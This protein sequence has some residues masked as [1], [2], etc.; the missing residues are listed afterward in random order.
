MLLSYTDLLA[1]KSKGVATRV[2]RGEMRCSVA[3]GVT[4]EINSESMTYCSMHWLP[5][6]L[7]ANLDAFPHSLV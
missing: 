5:A 6:Y 3:R 7:D 2:D 4:R 1:G